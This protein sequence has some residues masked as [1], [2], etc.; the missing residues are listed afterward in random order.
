MHFSLDLESI[1]RW[2]KSVF[3]VKIIGLTGKK[4][5]L[6]NKIV[7]CVTSVQPPILE[8]LVHTKSKLKKVKSLW[9]IYAKG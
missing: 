8:N 7:H 9:D 2:L 5:D 3:D 1:I 6:V 4:I